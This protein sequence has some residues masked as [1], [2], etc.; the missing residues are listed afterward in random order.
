MILHRKPTNEIP[1][2]ANRVLCDMPNRVCAADPI[3]GAELLE[4]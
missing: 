1:Q 2:A 3:V 4:V